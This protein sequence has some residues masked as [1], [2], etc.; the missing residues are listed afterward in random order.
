MNSSEK[1]INWYIRLYDKF[2]SDREI[3]D[4]ENLPESKY[5]HNF[6]SFVIH[7]YLKMLCHS[8][9]DNGVIVFEEIYEENSDI[10]YSISK[11]FFGIDKIADTRQ[12]LTILNKFKLI[13]VTKD[14]GRT[15]IFMP[16]VIAN[17]G[18]STVGANKKRE[19]I[20]QKKQLLGLPDDEN[21][22]EKKSFGNLKNIFL[23][24]QEFKK[25]NEMTG[26]NI[27][28]LN[29]Y[30]NKFSYEKYFREKDAK[31]KSD[32]QSLCELINKGGEDNG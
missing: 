29:S 7:L 28:I 22:D 23:T 19:R 14:D 32:Y 17:T 1:T 3:A 18:K 10:A 16:G 24:E 25:L 8:T 20:A 4:I 30:L 15:T 31:Y 21:N 27:Q 11:K 13:E 2:F 5:G 12:A 6:G 9:R 26:N